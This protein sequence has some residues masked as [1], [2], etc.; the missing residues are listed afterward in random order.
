MRIPNNE[1]ILYFVAHPDDEIIGVGGTIAKY[2]NEGKNNYVI[3][4]SYGEVSHLKEE[5]IK[6]RRVRE[7]TKAGKIVGV[8][9]TIFFGLPDSNIKSKIEEMKIKDKVKQLILKY[10]P[11]KIFTHSPSDPMPDHRTVNKV[12]IE[13]L[14]EIKSKKGKKY[15]LYAFDIWNI[16]NSKEKNEPRL[17]IDIS[18]FFWKKIEALKEF[19][20]QS[21]IM[22]NF[23]PITFL[24]AKWYGL[25]A[26]CKYAERFY[27]LR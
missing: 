10:N 17:Y 8:K 20:S 12:V 27:K 13:A 23:I 5:I 6:L 14:N 2:S 18:E 22:I 7:S 9:D 21:H 1:N 4:F 16:S 26:K 24:R 19:K 3:I 25:K 11:E 15:D